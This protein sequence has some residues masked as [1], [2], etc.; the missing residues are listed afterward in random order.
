MHARRIVVATATVV[1]ALCGGA[2]AAA[3]AGAP[4]GTAAAIAALAATLDPRV[5]DALARIDGPGRQLLA[6][7]SYL[8]SRAHLA[9]RWSWTAEQI[10]DY[11][12]SP[13]HR[14]LEAEIERVRTAFAQANPGFELWVNPQARSLD[15]QIEHWNHN[16][17]DAAAAEDLLAALRAR[18]ATSSPEALQ[19]AQARQTTTEFLQSYVPTPIP[20]LAAPGLSPHG[21]MRAIDFQVQKD[22]QIVAGPAADSIASVWDAQ[23][24]AARLDA[25]VHEGSRQFIGPLASPREPWHFTYVPDAVVSR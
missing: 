8:R 15:T 24:W 20:T 6:L 9:E 5:A 23:G 12:A 1:L 22:G 4:D 14:A 21:Q 18:L 10:A 16:A 2:A 13:E 7:R 25:A 17:S 11:A 19:P 3:E